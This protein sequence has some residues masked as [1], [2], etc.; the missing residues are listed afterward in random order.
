MAKRCRPPASRLP[1]VNR[2]NVKAKTMTLFRFASALL[3]A[4][5]A[6]GFIFLAIGI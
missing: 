1:A 6:F 5:G 2:L 4:A 3:V